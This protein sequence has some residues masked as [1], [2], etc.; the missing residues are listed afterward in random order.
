MRIEAV[1]PITALSSDQADML[2]E[3]LRDKPE[4]AQSDL[5]L[6]R[7]REGGSSVDMVAPAGGGD[8]EWRRGRPASRAFA[9]TRVGRRRS[10]DIPERWPTAAAS[11]LTKRPPPA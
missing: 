1:Q 9:R 6:Y 10:E 2:Q 5:V 8:R 7:L 4:L 11:C 3:L